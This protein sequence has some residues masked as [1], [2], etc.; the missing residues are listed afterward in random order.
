MKSRFCGTEPVDDLESEPAPAG[1]DGRGRA[2]AREGCL[3]I[4]QLT[5][6][7]KR[8]TEIKL[9][10]RDLLGRERSFN[11]FGFEARCVL[12]ELDH[13]DG[14]LFLDRVASFGDDIFVRKH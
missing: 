10:S 1:A 11:C 6:N 5:A 12:H 2:I 7:V 9:A 8:A 14:K 3:S 4:P 13:L